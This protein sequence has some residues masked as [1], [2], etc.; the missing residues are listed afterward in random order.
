MNRRRFEKKVR[1]IFVE[2]AA[3]NGYKCS[4]KKFKFREMGINR[5]GN[6]TASYERTYNAIRK[7]LE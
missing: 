2:H 1:A 5:K 3:R 6:P 4:E 7:A